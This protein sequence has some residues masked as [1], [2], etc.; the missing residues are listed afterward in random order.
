MLSIYTAGYH[1]DKQF[2][3]NTL[4]EGRTAETPPENQTWTLWSQIPL[5]NYYTTTP[6]QS[7]SLQY[8][9]KQAQVSDHNLCH[10]KSRLLHHYTVCCMATVTVAIVM[11]YSVCIRYVMWTLCT[12]LLDIH[13]PVIYLPCLSSLHNLYI[14]IGLFYLSLPVFFIYGQ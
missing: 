9:P 8:V 1:I 12:F 3:V 13:L 2:W 14:S 6:I 11:F 7:T 10:T 5:S 4:L